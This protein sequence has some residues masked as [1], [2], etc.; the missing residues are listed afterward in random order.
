M[1]K[2]PDDLDVDARQSALTKRFLTPVIKALE[3]MF[4]ALRAETDI[5]LSATAVPYNGK[6]YPYGQCLEITQDV[7]NRV[8][9]QV[10]RLSSPGA[11]ALRAFLTHGGEGRIVWGVLRDRY[12]QNAIQLGSLY[13]D[14]AND[15]VDINKP[16]VEILPM[17]ESGLVSVRDA[18]HYARIGEAYWGVSIYA[19]T[20]LPS[21]AP[22]F[23][24]ILVDRHGAIQLQCRSH[25]MVR[26]FAAEGF[27]RVA[28]WLADGPPPPLEVVRG[29]RAA[30][31][32]DILRAA[33]RT[34]VAVAIEGCRRLSL[35]GT[36][37]NDA[38]IAG[39]IALFD[40]IGPARVLAGDS[41]TAQNSNAR[42]DAGIEAVSRQEYQRVMCA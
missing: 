33:P 2:L 32:S 18:A 25:D 4:L 35:D 34:G 19:N 13:V 29:L 11:R 1:R 26:L 36:V 40:R 24:M 7:M 10:A 8:L 23:P 28:Q 12:F 20:A 39:M 6:P 5:A 22:A 17:R 21:L 16:K 42:A 41:P 31:P 14:V 30:T 27:R 38:W 9:T 37:I 3:V 15:T